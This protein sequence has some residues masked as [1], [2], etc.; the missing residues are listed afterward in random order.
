MLHVHLPALEVTILYYLNETIFCKNK[1]SHGYVPRYKE[2]NINARR[3]GRSNPALPS[4]GIIN[5]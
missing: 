3:Q 2:Q 1:Y 4:E 5:H